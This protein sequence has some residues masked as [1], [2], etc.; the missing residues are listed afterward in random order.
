[1]VISRRNTH[2]SR[3]Q[4]KIAASMAPSRA[5]TWFESKRFDWS[6][7]SFFDHWPIRMLVLLPPFAAVNQFQL[8]VLIFCLSALEKVQVFALFGINCTALSQSELRNFSCI[9]LHL[10]PRSPSFSRQWSKQFHSFRP[11]GVELLQVVLFTGVEGRE[12]GT[13]RKYVSSCCPCE[14]SHF[15]VDPVSSSRLTKL[16]NGWV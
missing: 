2:V 4:G 14:A 16:I 1:M 12:G 9:L 13:D 8:S 11:K 5:C 10:L 15:S 3:H 6:W 7:V